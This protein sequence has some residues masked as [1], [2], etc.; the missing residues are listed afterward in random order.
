[1]IVF[2]H[3][4]PETAAIW[5]KVR[6]AIDRPSVALEMPGFCCAPPDGFDAT[7]DD[8]ADWLVGEIRAIGEPVDLVGHD[9]GAG[10]TYRVA[11]AH[12]DAAPLVGGRR[13]QHRPPRLRVARLRQDL[14]D[15]RRRR[16]VLRGP[17]R[18]RTSGTCRAS[19][20]AIGDPA[21][22]GLAMAESGDETMAD[23]HP[24][25]LPIGDAESPRR[26][27]P[28]VADVAPGLVLHPP[29]TRSATRPRPG[30][31]LTS[32]APGFATIEGAGHFWPYQAPEAGAAVL[33]EFWSSLD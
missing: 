17:E 33:E 32:S 24:R 1:M 5:D 30:L 23:V 7:K 4:V 16:G 21:E 10:I 2:V 13:R 26:L 12:G 6:A 25:P 31:P 15:A 8:Y 20:E 3:G 27:G 14:A 28:V 29:R 9:W 11:T 18:R 19:Y 22:D